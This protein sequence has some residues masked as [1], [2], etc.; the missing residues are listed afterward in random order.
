MK[1]DDVVKQLIKSAAVT[2][3][4]VQELEAMIQ[5]NVEAGQQALAGTELR[6]DQGAR[7]LV[8]R[9]YPD[10]KE[11][12]SISLPA[13]PAIAVESWEPA[14]THLTLFHPETCKK[15]EH[16]AW[17]PTREFRLIRSKQGLFV[18]GELMRQNNLPLTD[19]YLTSAKPKASVESGPLDLFFGRSGR[20]LAVADR[21]AGVVHLLDLEAKALV[22]S[23]S[24]RNP[25]SSKGLNLALNETASELIVADGTS[26]LSVWN[27]EGQ[28]VRKLAPGAGLLGNLVL[29]LDE[30]SLFVM[31]SKPNPGL[32]LLDARS[33]A[34]KKDIPIKGDLYS[35][36]S[37]APSDLMALSPDGANLLFM[38]YLNEPEPFTPV[39]S[40]VDVERQKTTQRFS[41]KDG[42]RPS[43][44]TFMAI[45]PLSEKNQNLVELMLTMELI[46]PEQLHAARIAARE[47][48]AAA[49]AQSAAAAPV[50][51]LE[52]VAFE[53]LQSEKEEKAEEG[54]EEGKEAITF[55]PEKTAQLNIPPAAEGLIVEHCWQI[56]FNET[57]GEIN[58]KDE[59]YDPQMSRLRQAA[60][61]ARNELE[62][63]N[64]AIIRLKDF[65][66]GKPFEL[67]IMREQLETLL[68]KYERDQLV[69]S[70][71]PT[72]PSNCPNCNKP[73][74]GSYLCTYCG[75]E[76][77]RPEEL[78]KRGL[79]SIA[80]YMPL[81]NLIEGHFLLIDIEGKRLLEIDA[82]RNITWSMGKDILTESKVEL[83]FPR[84]VVRL[85]N[86]NTL[87]T[88]YSMNRVF[89][90]T[91]SG[92]AFWEYNA[93]LTPD[94]RLQNPVRAT[95]NGLNHILIVDQGR[96][97][98][99]EVNKTSEILMQ[100]GETDKPGVK[101]GMLNMPSDALR[102][103]NGNVLIADTGNHRVIEV[104]DWRIIWQY[105]N[106]EKLE[107]GGYG[108]DPGF[109]SY[110][111]SAMRLDN[112]NTLIVD[113]GNMRVI[114]VSPEGQV[115][116]EHRTN[117]GPEEHQ[118]DSPFR[119]AITT[120]GRVMVLSET[121]V[122]EVD[123]K[124]DKVVWA[125]QL[126]EFERAKVQLKAEAQAKRFMKHG[127]KNP[128]LKTKDDGAADE[129]NARMQEMI[130]KRM[131]A[132]RSSA[133]ANRAHVTTFSQQPLQPLD[134]YL[135]DRGR[136]RVLKIERDGQI[137][138][139]YGEEESELLNKPHTCSRTKEGR[140][141]ITD[142]DAHRVIEVDLKTNATTW[143]FGTKGFPGSGAEGLN[144]PRSAESLG[145]GHVLIAD[146]NNHRVIEVNRNGQLLWSYDSL[147][148]LTAPY[149]AQRLISGNTLIVDW[150][151]H[152]VFEVS[153][154]GKI[155]WQFGERKVSGSDASHLSYPEYAVRLAD[156]TTL[157]ADSRNDRVLEVGEDAQV[158]WELDGKGEL[159]FS[160]PSYVR[161]LKDGHTLVV[162]S[163]NRQMLEVDNQFKLYWK[164]MLPFEKPA[165]KPVGSQA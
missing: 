20:W 89:E 126:S 151:A 2:E 149:H 66:N 1:R 8:A 107:S 100:Y 150:G 155:V 142:T 122:M 76:I 111:Q 19:R 25:G 115:V 88:D 91:P 12:Y 118:M 49:S 108:S 131:A 45:N 101:D 13:G 77:E 7:R 146:Q 109:L 72:V 139:R 97:R 84:D 82:N 16:A 75:Y 137:P 163:S 31:A 86:R 114:Q 135:V 105:G 4:K 119:A 43:L 113:A 93:R 134:V 73:L 90:V 56:I 132:G 159:K 106:P 15:V 53:K 38:T 160:S 138:W 59:K 96:H 74:F 162:H 165:G 144:R 51:D 18:S 14:G 83:E 35:I 6:F 128:Y 65:L 112:G 9:S 116:W 121:S 17:S 98:V 117:E 46:T 28:Q 42:T 5:A 81:E 48:A 143:S 41:I 3:A 36:A 103:V 69:K 133:H 68:H 80:S 37:D 33:G 47:Q 148:N 136:S 85:S 123:P 67:V 54:G 152:V 79:I 44:L 11:L 52:R 147:D 110:P 27:F 102:L 64:G 55:K 70:G 94:N 60:S 104:E 78:L 145:L 129:A 39:I 22:K 87:I 130:A 125:C 92:R 26:S 156:G 50:M 158:V 164:F 24:V 10:G 161:R 32:K 21:G 154:E 57:R 157:I 127:V 58:L 34:L 141:L 71:M 140:L 99:I 63:H 30:K 29:S 124:E 40:V 120:K 61:R 95:S 23:F 62:W 153:P